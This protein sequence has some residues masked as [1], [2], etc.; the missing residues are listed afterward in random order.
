MHNDT[1]RILIAGMGNPLLADDG[2]GVEVAQRLRQRAIASSARVCEFT[3]RVVPLANEL[4]RGYDL[5]ILVDAGSR[6]GR[7]GTLYV[8]EADDG[9]AEESDDDADAFASMLDVR[10][11]RLVRLVS[12]WSGSALVIVCEPQ[13]VEEFTMGLSEPVERAVAVAVELVEEV[14]AVATGQRG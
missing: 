8:F 14:V 10:L 9:R 1:P 12:G 5:L 6:G 11:L 13:S 4:A 2:F 3:N 7:P